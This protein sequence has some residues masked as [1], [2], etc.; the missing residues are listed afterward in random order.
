MT[1]MASVVVY[2]EAPNWQWH[3][4]HAMNSMYLMGQVQVRLYVFFQHSFAVSILSPFFNPKA[5]FDGIPL[6]MAHPVFASPPP[7]PSVSMETDPSKA[8]S[9]F[10]DSTSSDSGHPSGS[11]GAAGIME[12]SFY[13]PKLD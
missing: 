4:D 1:M 10:L 9:S 12:N 5:S 11:P 3:Y 8:S 2:L 13:T 6:Y 7:S